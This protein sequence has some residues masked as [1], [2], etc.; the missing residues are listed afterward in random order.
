MGSSPKSIERI[1]LEVIAYHDPIDYHRLRRLVGERVN[2]QY[3]VDRH[4]EALGNLQELNMVVRPGLAHEYIHITDVG[5]SDL[6]GE[7][8]RREEVAE[9][10]DAAECSVCARDGLVESHW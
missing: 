3:S 6:G 9:S 2:G 7:T 5:W 8:E 10:V 4:Q 1:M